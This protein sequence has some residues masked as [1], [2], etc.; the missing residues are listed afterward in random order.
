MMRDAYAKM[1]DALMKTGR[2]IVYS[3]CQ[4]GVDSVW[5]WGEEVGGN[6]GRTTDDIS[7]SYRSMALIGFSQAGLEQYAKPGHWNDPDMLER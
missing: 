3:I 5:K 6:L 7:D 2:P 1:H 4:Y